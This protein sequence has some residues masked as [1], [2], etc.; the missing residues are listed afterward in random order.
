[1]L[2]TTAITTPLAIV[3]AVTLLSAPV[4][5]QQREH[6]RR[7]P[8][9]QE[10]GRAAERAQPRE[11]APAQAAPPPPVQS[12]GG[13]A[14]APRT[15]QRRDGGQRDN[16]QRENAQRN[17][18]QRDNAQRNER[19]RDNVQ[20][21]VPRRDIQPRYD[22]RRDGRSYRP[23]YVVPRARYYAPRYGYGVRGYYRPYVYRP[24]LSIGLGIFMG[25]PVPYAYSYPY[26][27]NVYGYRAPGGPIVV[28][29]GSPYYG[30]VSLEITPYDADVYVD[31]SFAGRVEDFDGSTQPLTLTS[32]QHRIEV[33][34]EG[35]A[36]LVFDVG[37][38]AGQIIPYRG[39]LQPYQ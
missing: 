11:Q 35:Y 5:A 36:P 17:D 6:G 27:I 30:G 18:R 34:A 21:A 37:V 13:R 20:R 3:A 39:D 38:Q 12:Q 26:P 25:Y 29:P 15:E 1:M 28:G 9:G 31:G 4:F 7:N 19:Q 23:G 8:S 14:V 24:H 2:K 32:G 33:Q 16:A 22:N 10:S